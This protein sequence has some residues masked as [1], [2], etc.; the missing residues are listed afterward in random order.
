MCYN[1]KSNSPAVL[2][3]PRRCVESKVKRKSNFLP[4]SFAQALHVVAICLSRTVFFTAENIILLTFQA[5][6]MCVRSFYAKCCYYQTIALLPGL[7]TIFD[8]SCQLSAA[9]EI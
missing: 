9:V 6:L 4:L 1:L 7:D 3:Q 2:A 5:V 8:S